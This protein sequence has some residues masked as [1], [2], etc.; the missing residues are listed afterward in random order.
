MEDMETE[1]AE[2][3]VDMVAAAEDME[4]DVVFI[5]YSFKKLNTLK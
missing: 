2:V 5:V 1:T 4:V 3:A